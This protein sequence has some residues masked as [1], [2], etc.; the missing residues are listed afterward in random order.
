MI[1]CI[2]A[3]ILTANRNRGFASGCINYSSRNNYEVSRDQ[4]MPGSFP[5]RPQARE[6]ALGYRL[7]LHVSAALPSLAD[8]KIFLPRVLF[9]YRTT[10]HC[11]LLVC[12]SNCFFREYYCSRQPRGVWGSEENKLSSLL[13]KLQLISYLG[14]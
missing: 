5:V 12:F 8:M 9:P 2:F 3:G 14:N 7:K 6:K 4:L 13:K 1:F 11:I 10:I